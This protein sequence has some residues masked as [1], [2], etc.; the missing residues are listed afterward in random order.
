MT[1][2]PFLAPPSG[3]VNPQEEDI[4]VSLQKKN[5]TEGHFCS[6]G[7]FGAGSVLWQNPPQNFGEL[8]Q[9]LGG[10]EYSTGSNFPILGQNG[11]IFNGH[12]SPP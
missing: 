5:A 2:D 4:L 8:T 12:L 1:L 11:G 3:A 9:T 6:S 7:P 10:G